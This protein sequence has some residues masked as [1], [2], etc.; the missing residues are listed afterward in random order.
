[1]VKKTILVGTIVLMVA[2]VGIAVAVNPS[3]Q[4]IRGPE[5]GLEL[6]YS[7]TGWVPLTQ[8]WAEAWSYEATDQ[9]HQLYTS[10]RVGLWSGYESNGLA[11]LSELWAGP[12]DAKTADWEL[13]RAGSGGNRIL[14]IW[15]GSIPAVVVPKQDGSEGELGPWVP[16]LPPYYVSPASEE[17]GPYYAG[18]AYAV[19]PAKVIAKGRN[20]G[21]LEDIYTVSAPTTFW[22]TFVQ[23]VYFVEQTKGTLN[24]KPTKVLKFQGEN[25]LP[26]SELY[27]TGYIFGFDYDK[28]TRTTVWYDLKT[29]IM[30]KSEIEYGRYNTDLLRI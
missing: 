28:W 14:E 20:K 6:V 16:P 11:G 2:L 3:D 22:S 5:P 30:L 4:V 25:W 19:L 10:R 17:F 26:Y 24:G 18:K 8:T 7:V 27:I 1:M 15:T 12:M 9:K 29:G 21:I 13:N 23:D